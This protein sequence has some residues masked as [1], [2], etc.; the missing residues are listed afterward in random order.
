M[1]SVPN[2]M[3]SLLSDTVHRYATCWKV[4][5]TDGVIHR[6]TDHDCAI[7]VSGETYTP[8]GGFRSSALRRSGELRGIN[9][10]FE[11]I[12]SDDGISVETL[13]QGKLRMA[14][15]D[16]YLVDWR[17]QWAGVFRANKYSITKVSYNLEEWKAECSG[18]TTRLQR[19]VGRTYSWNCDANLGDARCGKS[20]AGL[21]TATLCVV[22]APS[23]L[24]GLSSL[25]TRRAFN[26]IHP[27]A[28]DA[29][30]NPLKAPS[31]WQYGKLTWTTGANEGLESEIKRV[32]AVEGSD[33]TIE[34][35]LFKQTPLDIAATDVATLQMGC[36]K[37]FST[38]RDRFDNVE[39]FR[40]FTEIPGVDR[41][42]ATVT[43][44]GVRNT[45]TTI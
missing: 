6:Y 4:T 30:A 36:D 1:L 20:L 12:V 37:R 23:G 34:V 32:W 38:C 42:R 31:S 5:R 43:K 40:G 10:E 19:K 13:R 21:F 29:S 27:S 3:S 7:D 33:T 18:L 9:K 35:E 39:N 2:N 45:V 11:G 15:V 17:Y 25:P 26:L 16:E 28:F 14:A 8:T 44:D 22:A 24:S 41:A